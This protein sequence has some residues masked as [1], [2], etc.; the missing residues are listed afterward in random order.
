M[1]SSYFYYIAQEIFRVR[2]IYRSLII[3]F[4]IGVSELDV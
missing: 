3:K 2:L 1:F 4:N